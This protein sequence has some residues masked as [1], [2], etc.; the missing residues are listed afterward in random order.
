[1]SGS[2]DQATPSHLRTMSPPPIHALRASIPKTEL[3][4]GF[5]GT[6]CWDQRAPSQY[7]T[8]LAPI[9]QALFASAAQTDF[10]PSQGLRPLA[11]PDHVMPSQYRTVGESPTAQMCRASSPKIDC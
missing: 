8:V 1:M 5:T 6:S 3:N 10:K 2:C 4:Q 9:A 11:C 7:K